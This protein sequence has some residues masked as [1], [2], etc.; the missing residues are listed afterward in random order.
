M[1]DNPD[2]NDGIVGGDDNFTSD[3][4][5]ESSINVKSFSIVHS[6]LLS[7]YSHTS[8]YYKYILYIYIYII[9]I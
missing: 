7:S 9:N 3:I 4:F 5:S 8:L 1:D 6:A 2:I